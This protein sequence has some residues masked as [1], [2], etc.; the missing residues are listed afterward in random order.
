[1]SGDLI[2]TEEDRGREV[3]VFVGDVIDL[4][5]PENASTGF[6]WTL[7]AE[8]PVEEIEADEHD[9]AA[10]PPGAAGLRVLSLR[11]LRENGVVRLRRGQAWEPTLPPDDIFEFTLTPR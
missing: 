5:L 8:A 4:R 9:N 3:P 10:G 6:R 7:E 2:L 1:M 11:V